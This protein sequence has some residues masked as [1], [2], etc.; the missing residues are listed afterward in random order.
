MD[1]KD[2]APAET[3]TDSRTES[4]ATPQATDSV[5]EPVKEQVVEAPAQT[6]EES[7]EELRKQLQ[8]LEM[9]RN[10]QRN[11]LEKFE[12]EQEEKRKAELT[13]VE[14]L[15]EELE[16]LQ[17]AES[18]REAKNFRDKIISDELKDN[19]AALKAVKALLEAN[20][21]AISWSSEGDTITEE[22]AAEQIKQQVAAFT[23]ALG[24]V[25]PKQDDDPEAAAQVNA[26]NPA[27]ATEPEVDR[28]KLIEEAAAKR[29]FSKVLQ[30]LPSVQAQIK[31]MQTENN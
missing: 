30:T 10:L 19:P 6:T 13:E 24:A 29:D 1:P 3:V 27:P 16:Q 21:A 28:A 2:T 31:R 4:T 15:R 22:E 18:Q 11:K 14:R 12:R 25:A 23:S 20:P 8:K 5:Q 7:P 17:S 9:E 26:N